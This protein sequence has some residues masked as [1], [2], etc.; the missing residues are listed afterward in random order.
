V[1]SPAG[2]L[3]GVLSCYKPHCRYLT[4]FAVTGDRTTGTFA[5]P[6]SC[7][8]DDTGHLNA[9]EVNICYN[10]LLYATI[11]ATVERGGEPALAGW[12]MA[13][14]WRRRLPDILIAR[15]TSEFRRPIDARSFHGELSTTRM[16]ARRLRPGAAPFVSI[17]TTFRFWDA[18]GGA[19]AGTA[20][21]AIVDGAGDG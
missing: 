15:I 11:A 2:L 16:V 18:S 21:V 10:Q 20:R 14:F 9:V 4:S 8:I 19:A 7:Y 6:E 17:D 13:D 12:T 5:I 1:D 3:A